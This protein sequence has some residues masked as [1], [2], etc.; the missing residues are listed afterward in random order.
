M[1]IWYSR[2][3]PGYNHTVGLGIKHQ[4]TYAKTKVLSTV[5]KYSPVNRWHVG[6]PMWSEKWKWYFLRSDPVTFSSF[7]GLQ[8]HLQEHGKSCNAFHDLSIRDIRAIVKIGQNVNVD[9]LLPPSL[10][11]P[12]PPP[13]FFFFFFFLFKRKKFSSVTVGLQWAVLFHASFS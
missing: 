6:C 1:E 9:F 10:L 2:P 3:S 8:G 5:W 13:F 4:F 7:H 12:P 11:P